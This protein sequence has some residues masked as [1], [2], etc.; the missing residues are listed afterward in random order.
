MEGK[1]NWG[2]RFAPERRRQLTGW[3][4][5]VYPP[6]LFATYEKTDGLTEEAAAERE[7]K[8]SDAGSSNDVHACAQTQLNGPHRVGAEF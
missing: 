5:S 2:L 6:F 7:G 8:G 4:G 3:S 1:E